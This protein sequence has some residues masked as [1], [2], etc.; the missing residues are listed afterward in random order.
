MSYISM[1][2]FTLAFI[3]IGIL[4]GNMYVKFNLSYNTWLIIT[5]L[6]GT[7]FIVQLIGEKL[8]A[9]RKK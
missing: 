4:V 7:I 8:T 6:S 5:V 3:A 2:L 1:T 9:K